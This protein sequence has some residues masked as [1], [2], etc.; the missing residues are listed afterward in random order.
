[1]SFWAFLSVLLHT[2]VGT[3]W[4]VNPN[5][6]GAR[7]SPKCLSLV[8]NSDLPLLKLRMRTEKQQGNVTTSPMNVILDTNLSSNCFSNFLYQ[9]S[10]CWL[11]AHYASTSAVS[12]VP[13]WS[14]FEIVQLK[15][16]CRI[17]SCVEISQ[18]VLSQYH[19]GIHS[20]P[21]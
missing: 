2:D 14:Q 4:R 5:T 19:V 13:S 12:V 15:V 21:E 17:V 16:E 20:S 8:K 3:R 11:P 7:T 9:L 10:S 1:M 6:L 18:I